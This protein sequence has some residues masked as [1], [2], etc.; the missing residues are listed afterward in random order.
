MWMMS[1][2]AL[3]AASGRV[4]CR[5]ASITRCRGPRPCSA[6]TASVE[7]ASPRSV[8]TMCSTITITSSMTSPT[9]AAM[10]PSVITLIVWPMSDE[11]ERRDGQHDRDGDDGDDR[12]LPVPQEQEQHERGQEHADEDR[13][14]DA[15]RRRQDKVG[16]VVPLR[17]DRPR[18]QWN[19]SERRLDVARDLDRVAAGL[20]VHEHERRGLAVGRGARVHRRLSGADRRDVAQ[21]HDAFGAGAEH[22]VGHLR[23]GVE[24]R[25]GKGEVE[26]AAVLDAPERRDDV[27][28]PDGRG[29]VADASARTARGAPGRPRRGP[30]PSHRP[31]PRRAPRRRPSRGR[32]GACTAARS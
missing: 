2:A 30:R 15:R 26:L 16:L 9:A 10:P 24:R 6:C 32:A 7:S 27:G 5:A 25:L 3:D 23:D 19:L 29:E 18:W 1:V 11:D 17:R 13:V 20:L 31:A 14:A 28:L 22:D 4:N 12:D 21:A 8:F